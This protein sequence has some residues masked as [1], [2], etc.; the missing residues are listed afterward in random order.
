MNAIEQI[1]YVLKRFHIKLNKE[2]IF[3]RCMVSEVIVE[4]GIVLFSY[5]CLR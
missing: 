3:S 5:P 2:D 1:E 4:C